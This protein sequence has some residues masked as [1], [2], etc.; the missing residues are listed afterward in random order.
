MLTEN[1]DKLK[2]AILICKVHIERMSFAHDKIEPFFPLTVHGYSNISPETLS[3]IDQLIFRFTKLQDCMGA[4]LFKALLDNLGEETRAV[5]FIDIVSKLESLNI[6]DNAND[7]FVLLE[8]RNVLA[9][10]YPFYTEEIVEGLNLLINRYAL[11]ISIWSKIETF[12]VRK[13][14]ELFA[15]PI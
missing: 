7:W 5:P 15:N 2:E 1:K 13:F 12:T 4:K 9:D 10:E 8:I 11:L 6:I 14:P 3:Y